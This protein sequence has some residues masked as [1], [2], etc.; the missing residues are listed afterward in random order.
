MPRLKDLPAVFPL[1][2]SWRMV[3][4]Q[5]I[6]NSTTRRKDLSFPEQERVLTE[7]LKSDII[8]G[9]LELEIGLRVVCATMLGQNTN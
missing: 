1:G 8:G 7:G 5:A 2:R 9:Y 3:S 6:W 4:Y